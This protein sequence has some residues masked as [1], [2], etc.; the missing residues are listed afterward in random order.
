[1]GIDDVVIFMSLDFFL[2]YCMNA[3]NVSCINPVIKFYSWMNINIQTLAFQFN[4][5]SIEKYYQEIENVTE[6][7][8]QLVLRRMTQMNMDKIMIKT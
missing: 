4:K 2:Y 3:S 1:M 7:V 5:K 6:S 8:S